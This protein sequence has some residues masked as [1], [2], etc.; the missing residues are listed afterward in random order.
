MPCHAT[1]AACDAVTLLSVVT[2]LS[3]VTLLSV[4][5]RAVPCRAMQW[6]DLHPF[7]RDISAVYDNRLV[8]MPISGDL[9]LMYYRQA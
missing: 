2:I 8:S 5:S 7:W 9:Y 1:I 3:V 4:W 6:D